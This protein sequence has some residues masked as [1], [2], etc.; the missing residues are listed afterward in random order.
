MVT[1]F[2]G[3]QGRVEGIEKP[4]HSGSTGRLYTTL[5]SHFPGVYDCVWIEKPVADNPCDDVTSN[6]QGWT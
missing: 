3:E 6:V 2:R 5:G 1:T 4:R